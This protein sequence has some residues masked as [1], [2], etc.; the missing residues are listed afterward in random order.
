MYDNK[1]AFNALVEILKA[2]AQNRTSS[3]L[4]SSIIDE[5]IESIDKLYN[6]LAELDSKSKKLN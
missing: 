3:L 1:D 4:N 2:D 5:Y 6:K